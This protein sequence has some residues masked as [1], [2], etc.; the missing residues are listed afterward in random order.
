[1]RP[2]SCLVVLS[3]VAALY[4]PPV[5]AEPDHGLIVQGGLGLS[6]PSRQDGRDVLGTGTGGYGE[7]EYVYKPGGWVTPRLYTGVVLTTAD[8]N[9]GPGVSPCDVSAKLFFLG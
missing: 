9:C 8:S 1:M 7:V 2:S 3:A 4:S 6:A 5:R